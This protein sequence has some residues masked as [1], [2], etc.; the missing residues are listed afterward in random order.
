MPRHT[1]LLFAMATLSATAAVSL[2][3]TASPAG[4]NISTDSSQITQSEPAPIVRT[5]VST[6]TDNDYTKPITTGQVIAPGQDTASVQAASGIFLRVGR[7]STV[8]AVN[9]TPENTELRVVH[10]VANVSVHEP[11]AHSEILID[12]PS[13]Q[14]ALVQDGFYTFN[15]DTNTV[16]VLK[17]EAFAYPGNNQKS[18]KIKED[19]AVIFGG[20]HIKAFEFDPFE[21]R[22]DLIPYAASPGGSA[23]PGTAN[24]SDDYGDSGHGGYAGYGFGAYGYPYGGYPYY[25]FDGPY[26]YPYGYYPFGLGF[27][28][29]GFYGGG[30]YGGGFYGGGFYG[31]GFYGGGYYGGGYYGRG[32]GGH[33]GGHPGHGGRG[34]HAG[35]GG[36]G[37]FHGGSGG[38]R[39]GR[40][41]SFRGGGSSG[42]GGGHAGGGGGHR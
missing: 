1:A 24:Y 36:G 39:G 37:T 33:G 12:L 13:G 15:A 29:D 16:R 7:N 5:H 27:Y 17:G 42:G 10:G 40:G 34:P 11:I 3:Q 23:G 30:F 31:G 4:P 38:F 32:Y 2:A 26:S 28:G 8:N 6:S 9:V 20:P 18:I 21:A 25:G 14:S 41:G 22:A 35:G 19:H